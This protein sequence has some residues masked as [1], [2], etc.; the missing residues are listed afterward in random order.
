MAKD[1]WEFTG[2]TY[3]NRLET[4]REEI[5]RS[6]TRSDANRKCM[7]RNGFKE[8][9]TSSPISYPLKNNTSSQ[10]S[11]STEQDFLQTIELIFWG[12]VIWFLYAV[13]IEYYL[14]TCLVIGCYE[15]FAFGRYFLKTERTFTYSAIKKILIYTALILAFG[16]TFGSFLP[17][18]QDQ[19]WYVK[20]IPYWYLLFRRTIGIRIYDLFLSD[21]EHNQKLER[22]LTKLKLKE[23]REN[24]KFY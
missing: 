8:I 19:E 5:D 22:E 3:D 11:V 15:G 7:S 2:V 17:I 6:S 9:R 23:E 14:Q 24:S 18:F 10:N 13:L 20:F 16:A 21:W 12:L 1:L 4:V